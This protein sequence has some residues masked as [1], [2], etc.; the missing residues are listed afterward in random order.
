MNIRF[1]ALIGFFFCVLGVLPACSATAELSV[2]S[3]ARPDTV[4]RSA[5]EHAV[6]R[7]DDDQHITALLYD[8]PVENPT[9][10]VTIRMLWRPRAGRTPIDATATNATIH[11]VI[12]TGADNS[13]VGIYS[14]A[15]YLFPNTKVGDPSLTAGIW[16]ANLRLFDRSEGFTDLLGQSILHGDFIAKRDD[17][18][19]EEGIRKLNVLISKRLGFPRVVRAK[20]AGELNGLFAAGL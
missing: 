18:G 10:A 4:Y 1:A 2:V 7:F 5:F 17:A 14:G 20:P 6:Y 11:Y 15:G 8:G 3:Q 12:F 16:D 13:R 19:T 9:Q